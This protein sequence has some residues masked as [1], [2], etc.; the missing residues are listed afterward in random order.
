MCAAGRDCLY[1]REVPGRAAAGD[2]ALLEEH[3]PPSHFTI[4]ASAPRRAVR[5]GVGQRGGQHALEYEASGGLLGRCCTGV[6]CH[7]RLCGA[8]APLPLGLPRPKR[9]WSLPAAADS[10]VYRGLPVRTRP[11]LLRSILA[12]A[13][14]AATGGSQPSPSTSHNS[15]RQQQP[16]DEHSASQAAAGAAAAAAAT[17]TAGPALCSGEEATSGSRRSSSD[18]ALGS[19]P[20]KDGNSSGG[21]G[22]GG[23]KPRRGS[24][25][26]QRRRA[27]GS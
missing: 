12:A 5:C 3:E 25:K 26:S 14:A 10:G 8:A 23:G 17:A 27:G 4:G 15:A 22:G 6:H 7:G 2:V 1:Y 16:S 11:Y 21:G 20:T 24:K 19:S 18:G 13:A 9:H